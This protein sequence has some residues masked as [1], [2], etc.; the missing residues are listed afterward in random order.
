[1]KPNGQVAYHRSCLDGTLQP[2]PL[3]ASDAEAQPAPLIVELS[4]GSIA[5]LPRS[6]QTC[7]KFVG[8]AAQGGE[9]CVVIKP[10]QR[11][12]GSVAQGPAEVDVLEAIEWTCEHF[13]IDRS[14]ISVTG[15]SMGGAATWY[16]ASHYP[17]LF[18][19][20]APFCGYCD[21]RLWTKPGGLIMRAHEWE[22]PSWLGRGAAYRAENL[23]NMAVWIIH[24]GWD[25]SIGGGVPVAHSRRMHERLGALGADCTYTEVPECGHGCCNEQIGPQVIQWLCRQRR[26]DCPGR[27]RLVAHTLRHNRSFWLSVDQFE[28]YGRPARVD[29][30]HEGREL[31]AQ[32]DNVRRLSL[33]PIRALPEAG[34]R[35]DD[36]SINGLDLSAGALGFEKVDGRWRPAQLQQPGCKHHGASGPVGDVLFAPQRFVF[37]T[38]GSIQENFVLRWLERDVPAFFRKF[39]GGVHRGVF[40]GESWYDLPAIADSEV[41]EDEVLGSN[42]VLYG[43][44]ASNAVWRRLAPGLPVEVGQRGVQLAGRTFEA[45]DVGFAAVFPHPENDERSVVLIGGTSPEALAGSSHLNLQLLPDY[46]VWQGEKTWW[47]FFD[48]HWR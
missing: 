27:V 36:T 16:L 37:G 17:D 13:P 48:N 44:A 47:G 43:S 18:A 34:V 42:L 41:T 40:A 46:L 2:I 6:V 23:A 22:H 1:M 3:C 29:A 45:T 5:N 11:G 26:P 10:G 30:R 14:R 20:A 9:R 31:R 28:D 38:G 39:N 32:T 7:E 21:Y 12:P 19:A 25:T 24:G 33:G 15:S 8:W 4:P 35:L